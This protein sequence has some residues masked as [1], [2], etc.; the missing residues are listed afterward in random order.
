MVSYIEKEEGS[1]E[2]IKVRTEKDAF[3]RCVSTY[4]Q[5]VMVPHKQALETYTAF[6][7]YEVVLLYSL[8]TR[9]KSINSTNHDWFSVIWTVQLM[10][11]LLDDPQVRNPSPC[12]P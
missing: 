11:H 9:P 2:K 6:Y 8:T 7:D 10:A 1:V 5:H 12:K 4:L 3:P